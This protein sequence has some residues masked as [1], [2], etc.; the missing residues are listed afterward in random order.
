M[1]KYKK[2]KLQKLE[3]Q[4]LRDLAHENYISVIVF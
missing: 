3:L 1:Q 2:E 4:E